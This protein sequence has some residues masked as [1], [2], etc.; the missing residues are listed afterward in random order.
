MGGGK[1]EGNPPHA[2]DGP[3]QS[4]AAAASAHPEG[5]IVVRA[6]GGTL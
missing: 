2:A 4:P 3:G 1:Q 6:P 5:R